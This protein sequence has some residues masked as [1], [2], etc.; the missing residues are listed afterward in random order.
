MWGNRLTYRRRTFTYAN[1][2]PIYEVGDSC[3]QRDN[4][5]FAIQNSLFE[6]RPHMNIAQ[7]V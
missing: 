6:L 7:D 3:S 2:P 4:Q 5:L 1:P